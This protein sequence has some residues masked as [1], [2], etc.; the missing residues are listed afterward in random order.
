VLIIQVENPRPSEQTPAAYHQGLGLKN[1]S[2]RVRLLFGESASL[3]LDL[4]LPNRASA[5]V[6]LPL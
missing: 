3:E 4:S 5:T 2:A 1:A 6:R